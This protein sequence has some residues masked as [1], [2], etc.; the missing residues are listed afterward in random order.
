MTTILRRLPFVN[1]ASAGLPVIAP[2]AD[3]SA[4]YAD[5][6]VVDM[7]RA[8]SRVTADGWVGRK[9][10]NVLAPFRGGNMPSVQSIAEYGS[11]ES[12]LFGTGTVNGEMALPN[13][14]PDAASYSIV[15]YG[16]PG[17]S[18]SACMWGNSLAVSGTT[19]TFFQINSSGGGAFYQ[20]GSS[21]GS[22]SGL[23]L[24]A[25]GPK[26]MI[27]SYDT[28]DQR[29]RH[30]ADYG[31]KTWG[32]GAAVGA[33]AERTLHIG[34]AGTEVTQFGSL[35]GGDISDVMLIAAPILS[36]G[37]ADLLATVEAYFA[38]RY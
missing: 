14:F 12:L 2:T 10:D 32:G 19:G 9:A 6:R 22:T 23:P 30:R 24:Y 5:A 3:E 31:A 8:D 4:L 25:D 17:P 37:H 34:G 20:G 15:Y 29:L 16:R 35:D 38:A 26:L 28:A 21:G 36:A 27:S 18:D 33:V 7:W 11:L 13:G 1:A